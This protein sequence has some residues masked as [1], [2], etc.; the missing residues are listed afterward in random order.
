MAERNLYVDVTSTVRGLSLSLIAPSASVLR[1]HV[2]WRLALPAAKL[3]VLSD[4]CERSY[5]D[6]DWR[7]VIPERPLPWHF[8]TFDGERTDGYG[9]AVA[10]ALSFWQCDRGGVSL[11]LDVHNR[12]KG[13]KPASVH[14]PW[15]RSFS[16]R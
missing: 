5:G 2:R 11:W 3:R 8:L 1:V 10:A 13:V 14:F 15:Q 12:G 16:R 9:V 7:E 6:L 4:A